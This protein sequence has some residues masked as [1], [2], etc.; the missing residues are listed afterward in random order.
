MA[1]TPGGVPAGVRTERRADG[2]LWVRLHDA[3]WALPLFPP[4][5]G[6][7]APRTT[8]HAVHER[9]QA[10]N[11]RTAVL[12][13][14]ER[15]AAADARDHDEAWRPAAGLRAWLA[16][17]APR[18]VTSKADRRHVTRVLRGATADWLDALDD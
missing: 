1:T 12:Y 3:V 2:R 6:R 13:A 18:G 16:K 5:M 10:F 7:G 8:R 11:K 9:M 17:H 15:A 4:P 14:C